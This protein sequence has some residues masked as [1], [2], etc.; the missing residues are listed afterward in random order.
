MTDTP[1]LPFTI[2]DAADLADLERLLGE[3]DLDGGLGFAARPIGL[4]NGVPTLRVERRPAAPTGD[5]VYKFTVSNDLAVP[6]RD[7]RVEHEVPTNTKCVGVKPAARLNGNKLTW[8]LDEIAPGWHVTLRVRVVPIDPGE[9]FSTDSANFRVSHTTAEV[10]RK[11]VLALRIEGPSEVALGEAAEWRLEIGNDGLAPATGVELFAKRGPGLS[12]PE[13]ESD[14]IVALG[15][16]EVGEA[17]TVSIGG[18]G[19]VPGLS[20]I[21]VTASAEG[22][23]D[24]VAEHAVQVTVAR[25]TAEWSGPTSWVLGAEADANL[26]LH[27][28]GTAEAKNLFAT[29]SV[30][31]GLEVVHTSDGVEI[32]PTGD[33]LGVQLT[34]LPAGAGRCWTVRLRATSPGDWDGTSQVVAEGLEPIRGTYPANI[35]FG[36]DSVGVL[37]GFANELDA[38]LARTANFP[39]RSTGSIEAGVRSVIFTLGPTQYAL[40]LNSVV[41]IGSPLP[42]TPVPHMPAWIEG[43]ANCRGDVV[44]IVN[45]WRFAGFAG[46]PTPAR[47][48]LLVRDPNGSD[49]SAGFLV[50]F[51]SGIQ[52]LPNER[53]PVADVRAT[54]PLSA[55]AVGVA[56]VAS[57]LVVEL[58]PSELLAATAAG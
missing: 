5:H 43:V 53:T 9:P 36:P 32:E 4:P 18:L 54:D 10:V 11:P 16:L 17:I 37:A 57:G 15:T 45:L 2:P 39:T 19:S 48:L 13:G 44:S 30:P 23:A 20:P 12:G 14:S 56:S 49:L 41:E 25:V 47:R 3:V 24:L 31:A 1:E 51:V 27:N 34:S 22:L 8:D 6:M 58:N 21:R 46:T 38:S 29:W 26:V 42:T 7:V 55:V 35:D 50:D 33:A 40:P 52:A 28:E